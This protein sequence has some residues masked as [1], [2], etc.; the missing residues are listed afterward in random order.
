MPLKVETDR[1]LDDLDRFARTR[2]LAADRL[3]AAAEL[4][5]RS[6]AEAGTSGGFG[7]EREIE[8]LE[9]FGCNLRQG[10]FRLLV[11]GD[12]K[13]GKST[14]L[15]AL[16]GEKVLP[17][18]VNPCT[19]LLT[20]LRYGPE[21]T[22][23]VHFNDGTPPETT[24]FKTFKRRYTIDPSEAKKLE[25]QKKLAFP[26][27]D[28]AEVAYPLT[29]LEKGIEIVDSPGLNDTEARNEL[30]LG[31]I[32][33]CHAILFVLRATQPCTLGE[34]R[35]LENYMKGRGLAVFFLI[36]AWD[37]VRE[38]LI[39]P[40]DVEEL[41]EAE[42]KLHRVFRANLEEYCQ[43]D[44][45]DL[46]EERV[47]PISA[48]EALRLRVRSPD[49]SLQGTGFPEFLGALDTFLTQERAIAQLRQTRTVARQAR[50]RVREAVELRVPLLEQD[51]A[52]LKQK[53]DSVQPEFQKL[54][55][56][57]DRFQ[58]EIQRM[59][60]RK[61][62]AIAE[63]FRTYILNL[64]HTFESDFLRYQPDL[65]F[66]D[67]LD[68]GMRKD[69]EDAIASAFENYIN[70]KFAAWSILAEQE[71]TQ[72]FADLSQAAASYGTSYARVTNKI[73]E[74]LTGQPLKGRLSS[75]GEDTP[76]WASLAMGLISA[77]SGNVAGAALAGAGFNWKNI[78]LNTV[79]V[80]GISTLITAITGAIL[81]PLMLAFVGL[82][83]GLFQADNARKELIKAAKKELVKYLPKVAEE[84]QPAIRKG[85]K[86][87]FD[88]Y[89]YEVMERMGDDI[90]SRRSE[91][92][93]LVKQKERYEID[94]KVEIDRLHQLAESV[95]KEVRELED[96]YDK[97]LA[98]SV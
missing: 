63:S 19:A 77:A 76:A 93:N 62:D 11:L 68:S 1:F 70:D 54:E 98:T 28:Y 32:N 58:E 87:C 57:R 26:H 51:A 80:I 13:R 25:Q 89:E 3:Y 12:M 59:R 71:M 23:R 17:S 10:V 8:D 27:I 31:Y 81:G 46:Y 48:L 83:V 44:G 91:L 43:I 9:R 21:K 78:L 61:A 64:E 85:V 41:E 52:E 65:K 60:D 95:A 67:F 69:F 53:I 45:E 6:E 14:F 73:N 16:I 72:A 24:D 66:G 18:D 5:K 29:L 90:Q 92:E 37:Q 74:K 22:V 15:N 30:S 38:S 55:E 86:E 50:D 35:Y 75:A 40:D 97:F 84:Q 33:N 94:R 2:S 42:E 49:R 79:A 56:I 34:R 4:M 88:A 20:V 82:G 96:V 47:F 39:D 36:N 7:F